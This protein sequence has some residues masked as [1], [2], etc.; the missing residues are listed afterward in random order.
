[1]VKAGEKLKKFKVQLMEVKKNEEYQAMLHE[2]AHMEKT[3]DE[4]E[5]RLLMIMDE[6]DQQGVQT[7][8][9]KKQK[10]DAKKTLSTAR[11]G[12]EA[13]LEQLK[14]ETARLEGEKPKILMELDPQTKKSTT[15]SSRS[16]TISR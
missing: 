13:R 2:I 6:F 1:M 12:L 3:I 16:S 4:N 7:G 15:G 10:E 9:F 8:D 5:E 14:K 11:T